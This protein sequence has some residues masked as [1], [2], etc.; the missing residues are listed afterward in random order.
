VYT[1]GAIT[2]DCSVSFAATIDTF[3]VTASGDGRETLSPTMATVSYGAT[4]LFGVTPNAGYTLLST[5]GG[6]CPVGSWS[7]AGYTTGVVTANCTVSFSATPNQYQVTTSG[8]GFEAITPSLAQTVGY[9]AEVTLT[10]VPNAGYSVSTSVGGTCPAGTWTGDQYTFGP[11]TSDCGVVFSASPI[12]YTV[13][14]SSSPNVTAGAPAPSLVNSGAT[15]SITVKAAS[16]YTL[17][18][19]VGG[20]CPAGSWANDPI[21]GCYIWS[22]GGLVEVLEN[23]TIKRGSASGTWTVEGGSYVFQWG[24]STDTLSL[25]YGNLYGTD[26]TSAPVHGDGATCTDGNGSS[27]VYTTGPL[28]DDCTVSFSGVAYEYQVTSSGDGY[29]NIT[30]ASLQWV[31]RGDT[32]SF[33]VE[34]SAGYVV[35]ERI[36]GSCPIGSWAG[37]VYTTGAI[38]DDC[39]VVFT[40]TAMWQVTPGGDTWET[41]TP[42]TPQTIL[43]GDSASFTVTPTNGYVVDPYPTGNCPA[44]NWSGDVYTT[45]P[46]TADCSVEFSAFTTS[47]TFQVTTTFDSTQVQVEVGS[48]PID[49]GTVETVGAVQ[50]ESFT[51]TASTGYVVDP[52][53]AGTCPAGSWSGDVYTTGSIAA[54]CTVIFSAIAVGATFQVTATFDSTELVVQVNNE[55]IASGTTQTIGAL[56]TQ[57]YAVIPIGDYAVNMT[58]GGTCPPGGWSTIYITEFYTTGEIAGD[59]TVVF[60]ALQN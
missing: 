40:A 22:S 52:Y 48:A 1:T 19:T 60:S 36:S 47:T 29:E 11:I 21:V 24:G 31:T 57:M 32:Q 39:T 43:N 27:N 13:T 12:E 25:E 35:A 46:I 45:G 4:Q 42:S 34:P 28:Q 54:D 14:V 26:Q 38:D 6:T 33:T 30:P 55:N 41:I 51:V 53:P 15:S 2:A 5:V 37:D 10:V 16:G 59:C 8:D 44:G 7:A 3:T 18:S 58:V 56:Q 49:S 50:T 20:T 23:G 17:S 9:D